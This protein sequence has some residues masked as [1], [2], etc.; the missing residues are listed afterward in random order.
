M[1]NH[2]L[3]L[4]Q[5]HHHHHSYPYIQVV[6]VQIIQV[7]DN[8]CHISHLISFV[9]MTQGKNIAK[10]IHD[11]IID[12]KHEI[13]HNCKH[14]TAQHIKSILTFNPTWII[15]SYKVSSANTK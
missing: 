13:T 14:S 9:F 7:I 4:H 10:Y 8:S 3:H 12:T 2:R 11:I 1:K 6:K 5:H 15:Q